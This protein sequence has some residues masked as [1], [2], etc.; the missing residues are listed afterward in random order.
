MYNSV[1][2]IK[3]VEF[4]F[5]LLLGLI[6][7]QHLHNWFSRYIFFRLFL[8]SLGMHILSSRA[9]KGLFLFFFP[10]IPSSMT[11]AVVFG[12]LIS[13]AIFLMRWIAA[14]AIRNLPLA[15]RLLS[16]KEGI[17]YVLVSSQKAF[18]T[19]LSECQIACPSIRGHQ[20]MDSFPHYLS[21]LS[22]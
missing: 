10:Q 2:Y 8:F 4:F 9:Y 7:Y 15:T 19:N 22:Y 5:A 18:R 21:I 6:L 16:E 11:C 12:T 1:K 13:L 14:E 3:M 20:T 17:R